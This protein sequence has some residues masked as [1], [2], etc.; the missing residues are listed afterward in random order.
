[1]RKPYL[2]RTPDFDPTSGGIRVI[3]GLYGW[4]L[5]KGEI[6]FVNTKLNIPSIGIYPE[7][8]H[9]NDLEATTV[10][11]YILQTPGVM[12]NYG[13]P[14]PTTEEYKTNPIYRNDKFFVFSKIYD[15]FGV[16]DN[17][18]MFLPI[19]NLHIFKDQRK[20]R[21]KTCYLIGKG[22]NQFKHP[23]DSIELTRQFASDQQALA[24]LLNECHTLYV[25]D[26]LSAMMDISRLCGCKVKYYGDFSQE[27]LEK[28]EP[29]T[30]GIGYMGENNQLL[31]QAFREHYKQMIRDFDLKLDSFIDITQEGG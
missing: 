16:D 26:R 18:L 27:Q 10:V 28:Y 2:I 23:K 21:T 30:N 8:Y 22:T 24:D 5:A 19:L 4:L 1:M 29:G 12:T 15:T 7:I 11:R 13:N 25:Y 20:K 6:V 17:H 14:S 31:I 9:G 3:W